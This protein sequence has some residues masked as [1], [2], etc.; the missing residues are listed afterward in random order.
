MPHFTESAAFNASQDVRLAAKTIFRTLLKPNIFY[1][2]KRSAHGLEKVRLSSLKI[3][4]CGR[5]LKNY[6]S[7]TH[8]LLP[9]LSRLGSFWLISLLVNVLGRILGRI[10]TKLDMMNGH[11]SVTMPIDWR[12]GLVITAVTV[13]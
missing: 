6:N 8:Y 4:G 1:E 9:L 12:H 10:F 13:R 7:V 5:I 11:G 2:T 3:N